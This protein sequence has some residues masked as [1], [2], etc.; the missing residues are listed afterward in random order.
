MSDAHDRMP[1]PT[2]YRPNSHDRDPSAELVRR[3]FKMAR[4]GSVAPRDGLAVDFDEA[5]RPLLET[6]ADSMIL[7]AEDFNV[8][9]NYIS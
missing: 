8:R 4:E 2:H 6:I 7:R 9:I 1:P 5:T 3:A